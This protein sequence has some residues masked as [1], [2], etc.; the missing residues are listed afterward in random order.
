MAD[1]KGRTATFKLP[2]KLNAGLIKTAI[3]KDPSSKV[4]VFQDLGSG[5]FLV[6]LSSKNAAESLIEDGFDVDDVHVFCH[7]PHGYVTN[8][9][10]MGLRSYIEDCE[11]EEALSNFGEIKS[12]V[13]RLRYKAGHD[14]EGIENGNRLVRMVLTARSIPYSIRIGGEWCRIIHDNQQPVCS[15]CSEVGHT[16]KHCPKIE[17]RICKRK[18][19]MSYVC[20]RNDKQENN[21]QESNEVPAEDVSTSVNEIVAEPE[22]APKTSEKPVDISTGNVNTEMSMDIQEDHQGKKRSC[23]TESDSDSKIPI[24][25][26]K[27]HPIPNVEIARQRDKSTAKKQSAAS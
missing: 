16:R 11:V 13:I 15:E 25:R 12:A 17:C 22:A 21:E 1:R 18:G 10:I 20:D 7:P 9:S 3:E 14:L 19:H 8:V 27:Y 4:T 2:R 23:P 6:E 24:R 5:E 26:S